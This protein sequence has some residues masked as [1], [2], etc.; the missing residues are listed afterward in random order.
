MYKYMYKYIYILYIYIWVEY[1]NGINGDVNGIWVGYF[2]GSGP[3]KQGEPVGKLFWNRGWNP[4]LVSILQEGWDLIKTKKGL[5]NKILML[6]MVQ[7]SQCKMDLMYIINVSK[8]MDL[9]SKVFFMY[10]VSIYVY[11]CVYIYM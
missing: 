5:S 8:E 6:N 7:W 11:V 9:A 3:G 10:I 4:H 1:M 2:H